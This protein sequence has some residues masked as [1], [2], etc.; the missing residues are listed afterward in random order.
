MENWQIISLIIGSVI[1]L[2]VLL[3]WGFPFLH[4]KGVDVRST[5]SVVSGGVEAADC[6]VDTLATVLPPNAYITLA[7]RII[8]WAKIGVEKAEQLY[9]T[10]EVE[11]EERETE[12]KEY[13]YSILRLVNVEV[14]DDL[15]SIIQGSV[16]A[17]VRSLPKTSETLG[18]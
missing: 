9:K 3:R 10:S 17:A 15:E 12:A 6:I 14:T 7:D 8:E 11:K 16:L 13:I 4:R 5:L 18:K 2:F 1:L